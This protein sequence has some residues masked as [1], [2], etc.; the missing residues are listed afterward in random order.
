MKINKTMIILVLFIVLLCCISNVVAVNNTT[1]I[2][3]SEIG[4]KFISVHEDIDDINESELILPIEEEL[5]DKELIDNETNNES[6]WSSEEYLNSKELNTTGVVMSDDEYS[7]GAAS[8]ATVLN[9]LGKNITLNESKIATNCSLNGTTMKGILEASKKYN[10]IGIGVKIESTNLKENY[11]VHMDIIGVNHWSVLKEINEDFI[12]LAD[13]NLGNYKY[14]LFEF[15]QYYTNQTI[16]ILNNTN[17]TN[18]VNTVLPDNYSFISE[19]GQK[20][21]SGNGYAFYLSKKMSYINVNP[22]GHAFSCTVIVQKWGAK[23]VKIS[24]KKLTKHK[25]AV[26]IAYVIKVYSKPNYKGK[27]ETI[28]QPAI[29]NLSQKAGTT[30][31]GSRTV[32]FP[33]ESIK[34]SIS[35]S[36]FP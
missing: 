23:V 32:S 24:T 4:D 29:F 12:I 19:I 27:V 5:Y 28:N 35:Y 31:S 11:I 6:V 26:K 3:V 16:I 7:C 8:F 21:I 34:C 13:P 18:S 20:A 30:Y 22:K 9:N 1:I 14:G 2:R 10:L 25:I 33:I 36:H 17:I 15:N